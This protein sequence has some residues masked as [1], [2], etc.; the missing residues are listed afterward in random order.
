[1][2]VQL[3]TYLAKSW[4]NRHEAA[5]KLRFAILA[6]GLGK[7]MSPLTVHH[8]PKPMFPL[9]GAVPILETWVRKSLACGITDVS[10]NLSVLGKSIKDHFADGAKFGAKIQYVEEDVPSGTLGAV[11]KQ[12][13]G[14]NAKEVRQ[15]EKSLEMDEFKGTTIIAPSGDIVTDLSPDSLEEIYEIHRQKGAALTMLLAPIPWDKRGECGTV[16]LASPETKNAPISKSGRISNFREKDPDSP[17]NLNNASVYFIEMDFLKALDPLRTEAEVQV[18]EPFYDFGKHV[19]PAML[20]GLEYVN[21]SQDFVLWGVEYDGLWFDVGRKRDYL[22]VNRLVLDGVLRQPVPYQQFPWGYMGSDVTIDFSTTRIIPPVLIG[23]GCTIMKD[24][25]LGPH[26]II[27]DD[28]TV[29]PGAAVSHSV[30]W[31]RYPYFT[32]ANHE[33]QIEGFRAIDKHEVAKGITIQDSIAV[34]GRIAVDVIGKVVDVLDDGRVE[35]FD[36]DWVPEGPRA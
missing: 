23:N 3:D 10:M 18:S 22:D 7:R 12:A 31:R 34:G 5:D 33:I 25:T 9:A 15:N 20:H 4:A 8:I 13:L 19:F 28:W 35:I 30:L 17:S 2:P 16:E 27:G 14:K 26:A 1:M 29:E 11:C 24:V 32:N 36:I 6:A 21:L